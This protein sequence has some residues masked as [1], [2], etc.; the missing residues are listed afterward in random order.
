MAADFS[1][2]LSISPH[3]LSLSPLYI[4]ISLSLLRHLASLINGPTPVAVLLRTTTIT[5]FARFLLQFKDDAVL[6]SKEDQISFAQSLVCFFSSTMTKTKKVEMGMATRL[7][8]QFDS[9][10]TRSS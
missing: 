7:L 8:L 1:H 6:R 9:T 3:T 4:Y 10:K 5:P 2:L